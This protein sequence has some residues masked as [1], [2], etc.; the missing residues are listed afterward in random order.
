MK[1]LSIIIL[2][3]YLFHLL[4]SPLHLLEGDVHQ[5]CVECQSHQDNEIDLSVDCSS[6]GPCNN[7]EHHHHSD[8]HDCA[9]CKLLSSGLVLNNSSQISSYTLEANNYLA[10]SYEIIHFDFY[11]TIESIRAPPLSII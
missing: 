10:V 9:A 2:V 4:A 8:N 7:P 6:D 11:S 3:L 1:K 5:V